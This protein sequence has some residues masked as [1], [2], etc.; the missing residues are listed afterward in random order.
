MITL[1]QA[2]IDVQTENYYR[3][4]YRIW[5]IKPCTLI[6]EVN[7]LCTPTY[8]SKNSFRNISLDS[9]IEREV[10]IKEGKIGLPIRYTRN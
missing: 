1:A 2:K 5:D 6:V 10:Y 7:S 3:N 8:P 4:I 9:A